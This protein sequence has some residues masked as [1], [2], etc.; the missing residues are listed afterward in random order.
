MPLAQLS[1]H[2]RHC[3]A[4][5]SLRNKYKTLTGAA[6]S[7]AGHQSHDGQRQVEGDCPICCD[8]LKVRLAKHASP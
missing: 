3:L 7:D 8:E 1:D 5:E 4:A 6:A 2:P